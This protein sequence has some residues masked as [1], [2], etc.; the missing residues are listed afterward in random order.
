MA[1]FSKPPAKKPEP[2]RPPVKVVPTPP[3]PPPRA[4]ARPVSARELAKQAEVRR[5]GAEPTRTE[6]TGDISVTGVSMIEWSATP[7]AIEVAQAN[8]G[9]CAVLE[10]AAL[11]FAGGQT[12]PA[13]ALLEQG[14]ATDYDTKS[15]PLAWLALFDI[16]QRMNDRAAFDQ[17]ALQYVV[18]FERSA[19]AWEDSTRA[20]IGPKVVAGGYVPVTGKLTA[21]SASQIEN[22]QRAIAKKSDHARLD[23]ASVAGFD[24]AGALLLAKALASVRKQRFPLTLQRPEKLRAALDALLKKGREAGEGAWLLRLELLQFEFDLP[25]FDELAIEY[26]VAFE[27]SPPSWEP[28]PKPP[29]EV[30]ESVPEET[31]PDAPGADSE[32]LVC[33]GVMAGPASPQLARLAE[34]AQ[35]RSVV[36]IDLSPVERIDFVCAGA[37][38][39]AINRIETQ[40]KAVQFVGV[41]PIIRAL[42]LLIGISPRHFVKKMQ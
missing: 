1:F 12:K 26:A 34:F 22:L 32:K 16:L 19:P 17:L 8:P 6:P 13:R 38:L 33:T 3:A 23:L 4:P 20:S 25:A 27:Q 9:L 21:A 5:P 40:R 30:A 42:L 2:P 18:E 24:D 14:V 41:S 28:P 7:A 35:G 37:L 10:N 36:P 39:N 11:L 29:E 15:S 31:A